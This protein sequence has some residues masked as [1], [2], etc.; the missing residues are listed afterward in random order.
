MNTQNDREYHRTY[1]GLTEVPSDIP[2]DVLGV[3]LSYNVI[4]RIR[5]NAFS[6]L[7]ECR[8]LRLV[9]NG[10]STIEPEGFNGLTNLT[11]LDLQY[12]WIS[13]LVPGS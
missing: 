6:H 4:T 11:W 2:A 1:Q 9:R 10:I 8:T 3:Q 7:S 13:E 12:N 5:A